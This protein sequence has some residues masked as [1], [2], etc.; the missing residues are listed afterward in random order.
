MNLVFPYIV[1]GVFISFLIDTLRESLIER[2]LVNEDD[3]WSWAERII[4]IL[5]WPYCVWIFIK[6]LLKSNNNE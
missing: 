1:I 2:E 4:V 3:K 6:N 5:L